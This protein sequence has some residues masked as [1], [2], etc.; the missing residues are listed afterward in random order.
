MTLKSLQVRLHARARELEAAEVTIQKLKLDQLAR[1]RQISELKARLL[2]LEAAAIDAQ[3]SA[4]PAGLR[5]DEYAELDRLKTELAT[6]AQELEL[7][8]QIV[9]AAERERVTYRAYIEHLE[10]QLAE[11]QPQR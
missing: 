4:P 1:D 3:D 7:H 11:V 6:R 5:T 8:D 10:A 9:A 2:M